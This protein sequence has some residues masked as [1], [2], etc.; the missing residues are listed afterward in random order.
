VTIWKSSIRKNNSSISVQNNT[1]DLLCVIQADAIT[2]E[3][4]NGIPWKKYLL[5]CEPS[6]TIPFGWI[7]NL[8]GKHLVRIGKMKPRADSNAVGIELS[9]MENTSNS[10][11]L[12]SV[13]EDIET[14]TEIEFYCN[15]VDFNAI[16]NVVRLD[17]TTNACIQIWG[18]GKILIISKRSEVDEAVTSLS[19]TDSFGL[20]FTFTI[21]GFSISL[22]AGKHF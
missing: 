6:S 8:E 13:P 5:L 12:K 18:P 2:E 15:S 9:G 17:D 11:F 4:Q 21:K 20:D 14:E 19:P 16:D 22:V 10:T 3:T 1:D 7:K